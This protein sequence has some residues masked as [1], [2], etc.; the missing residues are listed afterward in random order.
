MTQ[1]SKA[2]RP[3]IGITMPS[4][5]QILM[6]TGFAAIGGGAALNWEWLTSVGAAPLLLSL[7]PC[8]AMCALGLCMRGGSSC[9]KNDPVAK[10]D[11]ST[12]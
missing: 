3:S 11:T 6:L 10:L 4:R 7:A 1:F 12:D 8:A 2:N 9:A 5:R